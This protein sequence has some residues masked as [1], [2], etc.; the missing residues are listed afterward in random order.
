MNKR[1]APDPLKQI[2]SSFVV[3]RLTAL[4]AL[5]EAGL[6][7]ILHALQ[8]PFTGIFV[9]GIAIILIALIAYFAEQKTAALVKATLIV[10]I[11]KALVSPHSPLPAY[12]AVSF[13]AT[14][15]IIFF[16]LIPSHR[17]AAL[18]LGISGLLE[19][20]FQKIIT[21]TLLY[22]RSL[23]ESIDLFFDYIL[24][25]FGI[26]EPSASVHAS[27]GL[28]MIYILLYLVSGIVIGCLAGLLPLELNH[29]GYFRDLSDLK[30]E[31]ALVQAPATVIRPARPFWKK[32]LFRISA[33]LFLIIL[34]FTILNPELKG[35]TKALYVLA[36]T[37]VVLL[38]WYFLVAPFLTW[39]LRRYLYKQ[40]HAYAGDVEKI[41]IIMPGLKSA[42]KLIWNRSGHLSFFR[43]WKYFLVL[44]IL[45]TLTLETNDDSY[46]ERID[47][48]R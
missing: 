11:I 2:H 35:V 3:N 42:S 6:G 18:L 38:I 19:S 17:L 21:L 20:A 24:Q 37:G 32:R 34:V 30:Q 22:G 47:P 45:F 39:L 4:W 41:L 5:N 29:T 28:I 23:W 48:Q 13:Q 15:G 44:L 36:R 9:G 8:S 40:R 46:S 14:A 33:V 10:L 16:N 25:Q 43:R 27:W 26:L 7:G 1:S 12:L 31:I